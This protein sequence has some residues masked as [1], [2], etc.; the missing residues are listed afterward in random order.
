MGYV[1]TLGRVYCSSLAYIFPVS[2]RAFQ[3]Q[4]PTI[5]LALQGVGV[6]KAVLTLQ[7]DDNMLQAEVSFLKGDVYFVPAGT[8][9]E[10]AA[11]SQDAVL[12]LAAVNS[13]V[14]SDTFN[15]QAIAS[16]PPATV[17]VGAIRA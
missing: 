13:S 8:S 6:V 5:L 10:V 1:P 11:D 17:Q 16:T 7:S 12:W 14:F 4:G 9:L 2:T 3:L 15:L